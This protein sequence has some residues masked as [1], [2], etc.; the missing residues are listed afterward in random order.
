MLKIK[1]IKIKFIPSL[2]AWCEV[3][4]KKY[5]AKFYFRIVFEMGIRI[6]QNTFKIWMG[7]NLHIYT[8]FGSLGFAQQNE[9]LDEEQN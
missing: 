6:L 1:N 2:N 8:F 7:K 5:Y 9:S 3:D 4:S